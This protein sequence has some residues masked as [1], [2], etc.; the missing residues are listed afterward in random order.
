MSSMADLRNVLSESSRYYLEREKRIVSRLALL[1]KG[2]TKEKKIGGKKYYYLSYRLG[3]KIIDKY[4][5]NAVPEELQ[6]KIAERTKLAKELREVRAA[7]RLLRQPAGSLSDF[8]GTILEILGAF[9]KEGLWESGLEIIGSWCFLLF[10]KHLP[11]EPYPLRTQDIDLL[12]PL[13]YKGKAHDLPQ[14]LKQLGFAEDFHPDGSSFFS[15]GGI[16][17]D[18]VPPK[19][20]RTEVSAAR[21]PDLKVTPQL[22]RYTDLLTSET[23]ILSIAQGVRVRL[24]SPASF[25]LHKL[26]IASLW[27]RSEKQNKDL[28]QA[29]ATAKYVLRNPEQRR[30]A[31]AI[32]SGMLTG[33]RKKAGSSLRQARELLPLEAAVVDRLGEILELG[34]YPT[35][36]R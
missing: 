7:L 14:I 19:R 13:P 16:R 18:L 17:I 30:Q 29:V 15:G 31:I 11:L 2:T 3:N 5:G 33:W 28:R 26:V 4:L 9:S 8:T 34:S 6:N 36:T 22:L 27:Q 24:P 35:K 12:I 1:P 10:Q 23:M 21:L 25:M 20:G 32:W